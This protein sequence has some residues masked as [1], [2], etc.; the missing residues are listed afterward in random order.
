MKY[1]SVITVLSLVVFL[2]AG[3]ATLD[4]PDIATAPD[5]QI[6]PVQQRALELIG[7]DSEILS[8][9]YKT[10]LEIQLP[11]WRTAAIRNVA[12][13]YSGSGDYEKAANIIM[14][15]PDVLVRA[16]ALNRVSEAAW[17]KGSSAQ[18]EKL[19]R[20]ITHG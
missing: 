17:D 14:T 7:K 9:S 2:F 18:A 20:L 16:E 11:F 8:R 12:E 4:S 13:V 10:A 19:L 1:G 5:Q 6:T 15:M 3:C